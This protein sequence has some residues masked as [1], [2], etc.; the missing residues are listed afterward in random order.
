MIM[1]KC[2]FQYMKIIFLM[3]FLL[4]AGTSEASLYT[5]AITSPTQ[6]KAYDPG[7][8]VTFTASIGASVTDNISYTWYWG[9]GTTTT[10]STVVGNGTFSEDHVYLASLCGQSAPACSLVVTDQTSN[11]VL[12]S[13]AVTINI[14]AILSNF[15]IRNASTLCYTTGALNPLIDLSM[16]TTNTSDFRTDPSIHYAWSVVNPDATK[17]QNM[18]NFIINGTTYGPALNFLTYSPASYP[19]TI[20]LRVVVTNGCGTSYQPADKVFTYQQGVV[21]TAGTSQANIA[22][23][24]T[25]TLGGSPT[26]SG[27]GGSAFTYTWN[28]FPSTATSYLSC[29]ASTPACTNPVLYSNPVFTAPASGSPQYYVTATGSNNCLTSSSTITLAVTTLKANA[30]ANQTGCI[31]ANIA[32]AGITIGQSATGGQPPYTYAWSSPSGTSTLN[33]ASIAQPTVTSNV[34]GTVSYTVTVTDA[35]NNTVS[36]SVN[37]TLNSSTLAAD[38]GVSQTM[39]GTWCNPQP[40]HIGGA[41]TI[42][43]GS[44]NY[45][46][47]WWDNNGFISTDLNPLVSAPGTYYLNVTDG[48]CHIYTSVIINTVT[49]PLVVMAE[50]SDVGVPAASSATNI[51]SGHYQLNAIT[52]GGKAPFVYAWKERYGQAPWVT[53]PVTLSDPT[54]S[55]PIATVSSSLAAGHYYFDYM[56]R[57]TDA[58]GCSIDSR[59]L[60]RYL[61]PHDCFAATTLANKYC[62]GQQFTLDYT[63]SRS[64]FIIDGPMIINSANVMNIILS[65]QNS[66]SNSITIGSLATSNLTGTISCTL[67]S[68]LVAGIYSIR[69]ESSDHNYFSDFKDINVNYKTIG[70]LSSTNICPGSSL[71]IPFNF[72]QTF[73]A[74]NIFTAQLSDANGVFSASNP[75]VIGTLASTNGT[76]TVSGIIPTNISIGTGYRVRIVSSNPAITGVDNGTDLPTCINTCASLTQ[77]GSKLVGANYSGGSD[78][79]NAVAISGDGKTAVVGGPSDQPSG[80][81]WISVW[82]GSGWIPQGNKL[83]GTGIIGSSAG[84]G[85]SVAISGDGNTV[86]VGGPFDN[87]S[88]GAIWV[89]GRVNGTWTQSAK[90][91]GTG[92]TGSAGLGYAVAISGDGNTI[93][94]GGQSDGTNKGAAWIFTKTGTAWAQQGAKL[95]PSDLAT[96]GNCFFGSSSALSYNGNVAVI[97]AYQDNSGQGGVWVYTR[98]TNTWTKNG[99]LPVTGMTGAAG[100]GST[101]SISE[102]GNVIAAG[103]LNDNGN[104]GAAWVFIRTSP[105]GTWAAMNNTISNSNKITPSD[106][107]GNGQFGSVSLSGNGNSLMIGGYYNNAFEGG[108]WLFMRNGNN[109][110]QQGSKYLGTGATG[111]SGQGYSVSLS[112][113]GNAAI[114]GGYGDASRT[115]A[116]WMFG[117]TENDFKCTALT[118]NVKLTALTTGTDPAIGPARQGVAVA[119]SADGYTAA[120]GGYSDNSDQGAVWI[121]VQNGGVWTE[122]QKLIGTGN[123]G[124]AAQG[125]AVAISA[126]GNTVVSGGRHDNGVI[127]AAWVFT[128]SGTT[129]TQKQ[130]L[131]GSG[132]IGNSS[133][134]SSV[135]VSGD[136]ST[137]LVGGFLDNGNIGASWLWTKNDFGTYVPQMTSGGVYPFVGVPNSNG[138]QGISADLSYDGMTAVIGA[139]NDDLTNQYGA[140]FIWRLTQAGWK[141]Q[142]KIPGTS[143][144]NLGTSVSI[145]DDGKT[146]ALGGARDQNYTGVVMVY[147]SPDF[148]NWTQ[149]GA[150]LYGTTAAAGSYFGYRVSLSPDGNTLMVG[151]VLDGGGKGATW[152]YTRSGT[153]WTQRGAKMVPSDVSATGG[154]G[155]AVSLSSNG[156][157]AVIGG[158]AD[159]TIANTGA[160][161]MY[162]CSSSSNARL[163][164][165]MDDPA[166]QSSVEYS[167][168]NLY[169]N[170]NDGTFSIQIDNKDL[171]EGELSII[172]NLGQV[173]FTGAI[174]AEEKILRTF[175]FDQQ[176]EGLYHL[177]LRLNNK[178]S[179]KSFVI[180]R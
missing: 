127:G 146:V 103:G 79:G 76:N 66:F 11:E 166:V 57:V 109:W 6:G 74:G 141:Q 119:V 173:V 28:S 80:A 23:G 98:S 46:F 29:P 122:Q 163:S 108:A 99:K 174:A 19:Y 144:M 164:T 71:S 39:V 18:S 64:G 162:Q 48:L 150:N 10:R 155:S 51:C 24:A 148:I 88:N 13:T 124:A 90:L 40:I 110:V 177:Y 129:W 104:K 26:A 100:A 159:G 60:M 156:D 85:M 63:L 134:G 69:T 42:T 54:I 91:T 45:S 142:V 58:E 72:C 9:D 7:Q 94:A 37:V 97:G 1:Q 50:A 47:Y 81:V 8:T 171:A 78:Q 106:E 31:A 175:S 3:F 22:P 111:K 96:T 130:M 95:V 145:S 82:N 25:K 75:V 36:S 89:F 56:A 92:N 121:Y 117:C 107:T 105:T 59:T 5:V 35:L 4:S 167:A 65:D 180:I 61:E 153:V 172:N 44:G 87:N 84:Q 115:G 70:T 32:P 77:L 137:I 2:M 118:K 170:P 38:P 17:G 133:Q 73:N 101:V 53:T 33:N 30:G 52:S 68:N 43:G 14:G 128:R 149:Q 131:I 168:I 154:F 125:I 116:A 123:T 140:A 151:G 160:A 126:D 169:P 143:F 83:V 139:F 20:T 179:S 41:P 158:S 120:V 86:A 132:G 112:K 136:G 27:G 165:Q 135:A 21:V 34:A 16:T 178:S 176:P 49:T 114:V 67:P 152:L 12:T 161:W 147:T 138:A 157:I 93:L 102:D 55:N 15:V 62:P 113:S